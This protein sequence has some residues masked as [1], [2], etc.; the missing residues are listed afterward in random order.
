MVSKESVKICGKEYD[1]YSIENANGMKAVVTNYGATLLE[2][3]VK[4]NTGAVRDVVLGFK[5]IEDYSKAGPYLGATIGR[6]SNRIENASFTI[7]DEVYNLYA[8]DK[9]KNHLH[10]G[11]EGFDRKE[12]TVSKFDEGGNSIEFSYLSEDM[13]EGYPGNLNVKVIYTVTEDNELTLKY[14]AVSDK[15]TVVNL[16]NH[17]YF[18]FSDDR[19]SDICNHELRI[20][21]DTYTASDADCIPTGAMEDVIFTP[22]DFR[23]SKKIGADINSDHP[24]VAGEQGYDLNYVIKED[25]NGIMQMFANVYEEDSG[26]YMSAYTT[27]VGVQ[28]YTGNYLDGVGVEKSGKDIFRKQGLCL[29]TQY[30]PDAM[31]KFGKLAPL[32][33]AGE[34]YEHTTIYK[35]EVR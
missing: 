5:D 30:F 25:D 18:N 13:E 27:M 2:L 9:D 19:M 4:D 15:D 35:F 3:Y 26:V 7:G 1:K 33:K 24:Q 6:C 23:K 8:N 21:S 20:F 14:V 28:F 11:K 22:M 29:E 32:L 31:N 34:E 16:T 10:G 12:W 17:T